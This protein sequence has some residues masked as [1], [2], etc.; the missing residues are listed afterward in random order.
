MGFLNINGVSGINCN[1]T[2]TQKTD[3]LVYKPKPN[4]IMTEQKPI[5]A[6]NQTINDKYKE[7]DN[8]VNNSFLGTKFLAEN[9]LLKQGYKKSAMM[10]MNGGIYNE[11]NGERVR[12]V[13]N[14][15]FGNGKSLTYT[16]KNMSH[17]VT[18]DDN[19]K[20]TGGVVQVKQQ[21]GSI[22][23]YNYDV[24]IEGNKFIKSVNISQDDYFADYE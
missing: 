5:G 21:D 6:N 17:F 15:L 16:N 10:D 8:A 9:D 13:N 20:E 7:F 19:G 3:A 2:K 18:Y 1:D 24:D 14:R 12:V 22:K 4:S 11:K 23:V